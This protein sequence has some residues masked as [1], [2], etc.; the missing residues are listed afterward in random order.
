MYGN[1]NRFGSGTS[2]VGIIVLFILFAGLA[3]AIPVVIIGGIISVIWNIAVPTMFGANKITIV[4]AFIFGWVFS[5]ITKNYFVSFVK[6][7]DKVFKKI[8]GKLSKTK[9][10]VLSII[11]VILSELGELLLSVVFMKTLWNDYIPQL[12]VQF[13]DLPKISFWQALAF[14]VLCN[15]F[16]RKSAQY[17]KQK[18]EI[19]DSES[20]EHSDTD[21]KEALGSNLDGDSA[22]DEE[23]WDSDSEVDSTYD[24]EASAHNTRGGLADGDEA[25]ASDF[26][27]GPSDDE[28]FIQSDYDGINGLIEEI[29]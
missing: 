3:I 27:R 21:E 2:V 10:K 18:G 12:F 20:E 17:K 1:Y 25:L 14:L 23:F 19:K 4:Q 22:D 8:S 15:L 24:E 26:I 5:A 13:A 16:F 29:I 11:L 7:Y 6:E 28:A 9:T